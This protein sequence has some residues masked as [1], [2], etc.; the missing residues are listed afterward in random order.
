MALYL[1]NLTRIVSKILSKIMM[2]EDKLLNARYGGKKV[3]EQ[4]EP[5]HVASAGQILDKS[6][7]HV[8]LGTQ[9]VFKYWIVEKTNL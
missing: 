4:S 3:V 5:V 9:H 7:H 8:R 1:L 2:A 6:D